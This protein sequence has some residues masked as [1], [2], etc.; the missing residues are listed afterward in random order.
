M[1]QLDHIIGGKEKG[2][3]EVRPT[4]PCGVCPTRSVYFDVSSINFESKRE[5]PLNANGQKTILRF[6]L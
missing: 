6:D 2:W 4:H 3:K 5:E 1:G